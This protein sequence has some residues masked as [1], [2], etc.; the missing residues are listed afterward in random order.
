M[1][2]NWQKG[3][4]I[5]RIDNNGNYEPNNCRFVS[6]KENMRNRSNTIIYKGKSLGEWCEQLGLDYDLIYRKIY[7]SHWS[8]EKALSMTPRGEK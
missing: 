4:Q 3:L 6:A 1:E 5:D 8:F 2:N 7:E